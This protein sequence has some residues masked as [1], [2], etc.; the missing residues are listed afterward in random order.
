MSKEIDKKASKKQVSFS[1]WIIR[2]NVIAIIWVEL[3]LSGIVF[4][5]FSHM[6]Q[7]DYKK[8]AWAGSAHA[9]SWLDQIND[10]EYHYDET[11]NSLYKGD[12]LITDKALWSVYSE[13]CDMHHT[14]FWGDTRILSD[15]KDSNGKSVVGT[16]LA[17][18]SIIE[19]VK[20]EGYYTQNK[21]SIAGVNYTVC[22]YPIKNGDTVVGMMFTGVNEKVTTKLIYE[23]FAALLFA[24]LLLAADIAFT[25]VKLI[26][27]RTKLFGQNLNNVAELTDEKKRSVIE[28]GDKTNN[29][30]RQI[31]TAIEQ[32][33]TA[34]NDQ[35]ENTEEIMANMEEF[36]SSLDIIVDNLKDT[37]DSAESSIT[38]I[39]EL[40]EKLNA[41]EQ[42]SNA[43]S[44]E[45]LELSREVQESRETVSNINS[46]IDTI[47]DI[48]MQI[49]I[50]SFNA[51]IEAARAGESGKGF[52][53]VANSIKELSD[54]TKESLED[55]TKTVEEVN[56]K[57]TE[58]ADASN[59]LIE[60]NNE[61]AK[62]LSETTER[63]DVVTKS[64]EQIVENIEAINRESANVIHGKD[65]VVQTVA[66]L[67]A[68][69]QQNAA[70]SE[71]IKATADEVI[72]TTGYLLDE[73]AKLNE[74]S[75]IVDDV[76]KS[77]SD[78][79]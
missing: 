21:V 16:K 59:E 37:S 52:S 60:K 50:L 14:I 13:D 47:N 61:V 32:V 74:I 72:T 27:K 2:T 17:D 44:D 1:T 77:F 48:A 70:M 41:L 58:T 24:S 34:V 25:L 75:K 56:N 5:F 22:Y 65:E 39:G 63:M 71:E 7:S 46:I 55:I 73:I 57:M 35:A 12:Y 42:A 29:N 10:G 38:L 66:S 30:M 68:S 78:K 9:V 54:K 67:A 19:A 6:S 79:Y 4:L 62:A 45:I 40:K 18:K 76:K 64:F 23:Y 36:G 43:N 26:S 53:V 49:T 28:L 11:T 31:D 51:S 8:V 69:S 33:A 15:I 3:I 20:N